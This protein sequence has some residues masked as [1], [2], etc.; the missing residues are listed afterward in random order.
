MKEIRRL[1]YDDSLQEP[2][3]SV[4]VYAS[5]EVSNSRAG[6]GMFGVGCGGIARRVWG[7]R[8]SSSKLMTAWTLKRPGE[9]GLL[10]MSSV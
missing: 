7:W 10:L 9:G 2:R 5:L 6:L 1:L 3:A 4:R 8:G